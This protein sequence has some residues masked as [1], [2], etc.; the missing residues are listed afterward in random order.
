MDGRYFNERRQRRLEVMAENRRLRDA[1]T[2]QQQL[3]ELD[4]RL[5][6][7]VGAKRERVKLQEKLG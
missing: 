5:G 7:G 3:E 6:V 1:R 4:R 2:P